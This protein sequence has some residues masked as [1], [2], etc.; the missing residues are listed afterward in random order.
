MAG[1]RG[2]PFFFF[3]TR[4]G[5]RKAF[6]G[7]HVVEDTLSLSKICLSLSLLLFTLCM[8]DMASF[9]NCNLPLGL[10]HSVCMRKA[11]FLLIKAGAPKTF[12]RE[13]A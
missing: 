8:S 5:R 11:F 12:S 2:G 1:W 3:F 7:E 10:K 6:V 4:T 9:E 13:K